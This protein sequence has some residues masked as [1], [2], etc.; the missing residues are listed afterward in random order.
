MKF[1]PGFSLGLATLLFAAGSVFAGDCGC[2]SATG[3]GSVVSGTVVG[4]GNTCGCGAQIS[5]VE[6]TILVPTQVTEMRTVNKTASKMEA[7]TRTYT[8]TR[9]V[10]RTETKTNTTTVMVPKKETKQ[11]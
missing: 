3:S 6:K 7:R 2:G 10:P 9:Q 4:G 11:V 8:V 1:C 5:Y